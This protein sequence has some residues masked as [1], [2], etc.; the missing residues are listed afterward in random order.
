MKFVPGDDI[1]RALCATMSHEYMR[2]DDA[3]HEFAR[4]REVMMDHNDDRRVAYVTY[5][6]YARFVH[7]LYEFQ[8][9]CAQR[10]M[11]D[12]NF[13]VKG[14]EA[15]RLIGSHAG[16][17]IKRTHRGYNQAPY[18]QLP[19]PPGVLLAVTDRRIGANR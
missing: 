11:H 19:V 2:C 12:T 7:H 18:N 15:D 17:A 6:A 8:M 10:D 13:Q 4:S 9:G 14:E 16:R 3:L 1:D 5:N